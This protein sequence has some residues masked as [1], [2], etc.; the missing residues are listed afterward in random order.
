M[1]GILRELSVPRVPLIP[2][3]FPQA[4]ASGEKGK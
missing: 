3:F 1:R 2:T 4:V